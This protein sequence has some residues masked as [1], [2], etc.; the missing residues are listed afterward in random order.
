MREAIV[1]QFHYNLANITSR[2]AR[3]QPPTSPKKKN[4][5]AFVAPS[6]QNKTSPLPYV[7][8]WFSPRVSLETAPLFYIYTYLLFGP[9]CAACA[10]TGITLRCSVR[11]VSFVPSPP[12]PPAVLSMLPFHFNTTHTSFTAYVFW[13]VGYFDVYIHEKTPSCRQTTA[14]CLPRRVLALGGGAR[15]VVCHKTTLPSLVSENRIHIS[16]CFWSPSLHSSSIVKK[17]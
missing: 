12:P 13:G 4:K 17:Q 11:A 6:L 16:M 7:P 9:S 3:R 5:K 15:S 14:L 8:F 1:Y 10:R 2:S